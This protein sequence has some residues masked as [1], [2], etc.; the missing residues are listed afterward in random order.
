MS[1][2]RY[3]NELRA[4]D[5]VS[6]RQAAKEIGISEGYFHNIISGKRKSPQ[7][8]VLYK[9]ARRY[10]H[11]TQE[12]RIVYS[13]LMKLAGHLD[14][15]P[16]NWEQEQVESLAATSFPPEIE[17]IAERLKSFQNIE[18]LKTIRSINAVIDLA[19]SL[20]GSQGPRDIKQ[21]AEVMQ[22]PRVEQLAQQIN[23]LHPE[24]QAMLLPA[25][26]NQLNVMITLYHKGTENMAGINQR[27]DEEVIDLM[28][29]YINN[30]FK[31]ILE[32]DEEAVED[33]MEHLSQTLDK[34]DEEELIR[35]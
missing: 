18:Q 9:I 31:R 14:W 3:V 16:R 19:Q 30:A 6:I 24:L 8:D 28:P 2:A 22:N 7:P 34:T 4:N 32:H 20:Q 1:L 17:Q 33:L 25:I 5:G 11:N 12:S 27:R 35:A 26:Q 21:Q 13:K 10:G 23:D 15:M 29:N